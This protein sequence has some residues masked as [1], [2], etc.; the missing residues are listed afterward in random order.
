MTDGVIFDR[1]VEDAGLQQGLLLCAYG[2]Q[3]YAVC[4]MSF[5]CFTDSL[6]NV[7]LL[8]PLDAGLYYLLAKRYAFSLAR[9]CQMD[10]KGGVHASWM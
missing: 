4:A 1:L 6:L 10:Q 8:S 2:W 7:C 5:T 3:C 9:I